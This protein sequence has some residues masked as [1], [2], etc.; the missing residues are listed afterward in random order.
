[1]GRV[2]AMMMDLEEKF[3]DKAVMVADDCETWHEF[4]SKME[5][6][7]GLVNHMGLDD[8]MNMMAEIWTEHQESAGKEA[9]GGMV[10]DD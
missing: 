3:A 7:M 10:K 1:M 4:S 6:H 5:S 9:Y 8:V 2:K